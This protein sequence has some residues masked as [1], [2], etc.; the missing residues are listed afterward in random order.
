MRLL[1]RAIHYFGSN[2]TTSYLG[3]FVIKYF[4]LLS[5]LQNKPKDFF[6]RLKCNKITFD[7]TGLGRTEYRK[8][9]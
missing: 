9:V 8:E 2:H 1:S 7:S 6:L 4:N 5:V 3:Y